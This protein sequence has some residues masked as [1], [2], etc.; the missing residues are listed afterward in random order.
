MLNSAEAVVQG[1]LRPG[2]KLLWAGQPKSGFVL[3]PTDALL[4]PFS[5]L[6]GGFALF[7]EWSVL[8]F[9]G[10]T[11]FA[12]WGIPFVL[13]GIYFIAGRFFV[14]A[15]VRARTYYGVTPERVIIVTG[16]GGK[17][18]KSLNLRTLT[19]L[20]LDERGDGSGT[21]TFGATLPMAWW[22]TG[23]A[24]P[25]ADRYLPPSFAMIAS[26]RSVYDT[27]QDAQA[28]ALMPREGEERG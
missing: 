7:W 22:T 12:L 3:R 2:E 14:D 24:W 19:D 5:L 10:S 16:A 17:K 4:I 28:R 8:S 1:Q 6:W 15:S 26:A 13:A 18:V 27:I 21:I 25:G 20:S 9:G 11:F 23:L